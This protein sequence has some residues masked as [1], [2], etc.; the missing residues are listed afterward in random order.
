MSKTNLENQSFQYV[1]MG[2]KRKT[3]KPTPDDLISSDDEDTN[4]LICV[5]GHTSKEKADNILNQ[6]LTEPT[7][8]DTK[9]MNGMHDFYIE[10]VPEKD[11]WWNNA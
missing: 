11:C 3:T 10:A 8:N 1:V 6:M 4:Y 5:I 9:L 7:D 2:R